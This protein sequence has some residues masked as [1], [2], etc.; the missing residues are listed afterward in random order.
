MI[1]QDLPETVTQVTAE[2][3]TEAMAYNFFTPQLIRGEAARYAKQ[4]LLACAGNAA[5]LGAENF[6]PHPPVCYDI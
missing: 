5:F 1:L 6:A 3:N 2:P 4:R